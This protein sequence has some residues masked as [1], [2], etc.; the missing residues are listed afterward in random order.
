MDFQP[1]EQQIK[2]RKE[3]FQVCEDLAKKKPASYVGFESQFDNEE[4]W[5]STALAPRN[6]QKGVGWHWDGLRNTAATVI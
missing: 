2:R 3:F 5:L 1:T 6:S 4:G